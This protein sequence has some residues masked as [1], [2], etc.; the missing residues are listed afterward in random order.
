MDW[1]VWRPTSRD[2]MDAMRYLTREQARRIDRA[3][4]ERYGVPVL[5][6]ME[7]AGRSAADVVCDMLDND[8]VGQ[9]LVLCGV[10]NNGGDGL[11]LAR[12][13]HNRGADAHVLIVGDPAKYRGEALV[14]FKITQAM[15]IHTFVVDVAKLERSRPT[16]IVDAIFG[17]GLT[18]RPRDP[19]D[20]V[21]RAAMST[22]SPILSL[23]IP[24]GLDADTG[25][26]LSPQTIRATRTVTFVAAKKGFSS[27]PARRYLGQV[28]VG[29]IGCPRRLVE[30]VLAGA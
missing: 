16:L 12:H 17:T 19:F 8:C 24:S 2:S 14:N 11:V 29:D 21:A 6:L 20:E 18:E 22:G 4:E 5:M 26:P 15:G 25:E 13:L 10:G 23:D 7:N 30:E 27:E 9:V 28:V 1:A 3:A